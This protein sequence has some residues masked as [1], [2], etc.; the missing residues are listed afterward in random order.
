[1]KRERTTDTCIYIKF[2]AR[3]WEYIHKKP[4][5]YIYI[6]MQWGVNKSC[7]TKAVQIFIP[8]TREQLPTF[9]C[10]KLL[11]TLARIYINVST[12]K[13]LLNVRTKSSCLVI[14]NI[15]ICIWKLDGLEWSPGESHTCTS[16]AE[17]VGSRGSIWAA[18]T[19][20]VQFN[21]VSPNFSFFYFSFLRR[22]GAGV[23]RTRERRG[24]KSRHQQLSFRTGPF[25]S[26]Q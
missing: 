6:C 13:N 5:I 11:H 12:N 8:A 17:S 15:Y 3:V 1:M 7:C 10:A 26:I 16:S 2:R 22:S 14:R 4:L 24:E 23:R 9:P 25:Q 18:A 20:K 19:W 21:S